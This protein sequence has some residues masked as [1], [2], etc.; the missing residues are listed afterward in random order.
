MKN[1]KFSL[2]LVAAAA[3]RDEATRFQDPVTAGMG[4]NVGRRIAERT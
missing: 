2:G 1:P 3:V 4:R